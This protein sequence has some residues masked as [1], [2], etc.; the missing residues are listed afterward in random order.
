MMLLK[1]INFKKQP[2]CKRHCSK[3]TIWPHEKKR[4]Q[5]YNICKSPKREALE[6]SFG[7]DSGMLFLRPLWF[8]HFHRARD[9]TLHQSNRTVQ[10]NLEHCV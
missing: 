5:T 2:E 1:M 10:V 9:I 6:D 8:S 3:S 4:P 7:T